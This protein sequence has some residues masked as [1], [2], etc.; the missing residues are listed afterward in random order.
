MG[1]Q[2]Q[3]WK[4]TIRPDSE[5]GFDA[6]Y[7]CKELGIVGIGWSHGYEQEQPRDYSHAKDLMRNHWKTDTI[8]R[9]IDKLFSDM[10]PGDHLWMHRD[11][12]YYLCI[13]GQKH[14]LA[15]E[16]CEDFRKYD[17]GHAIEA[18]WIKVPDSLVS[19]SIQ[20][21]VIARRM[22]QKIDLSPVELL[23]NKYLQQ[24]LEKDPAWL[25]TI[26]KAGL[27]DE[28]KK[29]TQDALFKLMSPDDVEDVIAAKLQTEG[30]ILLKS[31]CFR[32]KPKF[33]FSMTNMDERVCLVQVK[34]GNRPDSLPPSEYEQYLNGANEIFLFSTNPEPYPGVCPQGI[35]CFTKEEVTQWMK[36]NYCLLSPTLKIKIKLS[37]EIAPINVLQ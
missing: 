16:I 23:L 27:T 24:N 1:R 15:R 22:I 7:K 31:T 36:S 28:I 29:M 32:S 33:E 12:F 10:K 18:R 13:A 34:S 3:S 2:M 20:R 11:G 37:T 14:Y 30:W 6:F 25:P 17:L 4:F 26:D 9:E 19:G 8:A 5:T 21:G 35:K